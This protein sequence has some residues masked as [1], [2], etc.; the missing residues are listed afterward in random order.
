MNSLKT[1]IKLFVAVGLVYWIISRGSLDLN[2]LGSLLRPGFVALALCL[3]L[4]N[5]FLNNYRWVILMKGQG[6]QTSIRETLPLT[7]IGMFFNFAMPGGVGGDVVK[8]YY[9]LQDHPERRLAAATSV[10]MDRLVGFFSMIVFSIIAL[11]WEPSLASKSPH[12][13][14]LAVSIWAVF[15][16]FSLIF[17]FALSRRV[18][19]NPLINKVLLAL[20]GGGML[21]RFYDALHSYRSSLS[22]LAAGLGL[23]LVSQACGLMVF[24][25]AGSAMGYDVPLSTY[26]LCVPLGL[27]ATSLPIAPAG[28]GVGQAVFLFLFNWA[29]GT[30]STLGPNLITVNQALSL[31]LGL[32]GAVLYFTRKKPALAEVA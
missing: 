10:L 17:C 9:L 20:P 6:F 7:F 5:I 31:G 11:L 19:Q 21:R 25:V 27:I 3:M 14:S 2:V 13:Q 8:G 28:L 1:L 18:N 22:S 23:S 16:G 29:T 12:L 24:V 26:I 30:E 32:I 4:S 15:F